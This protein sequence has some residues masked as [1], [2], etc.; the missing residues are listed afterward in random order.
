[1]SIL[2]LTETEKKLSDTIAELNE[3]IEV[4]EKQ[5]KRILDTKVLV[6]N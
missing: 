2:N 1:M 6:K 4:L 3:R 5:V